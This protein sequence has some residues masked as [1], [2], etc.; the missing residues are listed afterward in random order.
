MRR[1]ARAR[2]RARGPSSQ[3][4]DERARRI[5][6]DDVEG[7]ARLAPQ[8]LEEAEQR[9]GLAHLRA[10]HALDDVAVAEAEPCEEAVV[11]DLEQ[12]EAGRAS[13]MHLRD[14]AELRH[15]PAQVVGRAGEL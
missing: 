1:R 7:D 2:G 13:V 5:A 14:R 11:A 6:A 3:V 12:T 10:V 9:R 15:E 4:V 8:P